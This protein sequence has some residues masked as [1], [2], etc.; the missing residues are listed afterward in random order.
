M[1]VLL[2][3][4]VFPPIC[5]GSGWSTY[6]LARGLRARGHEITI[7]RPRIGRPPDE[8]GDFDGFRPLEFRA[9]APDVP[10]AR[11]Y[12]KTD[13]LCRRLAG[14]LRPLI[15]ERSID[16]VHAQHRLTGPPSVAAARAEGVPVVCTIRDYWP[17]C[18]WSDLIHDPASEELCP[19]CTPGM[20]TRCIRPRAGRLWPLAA[21]LIPYMRASLRRMQ[22]ALA[23]AGAVVAVGSAIARDLVARAPGLDAGRVNIIPNAVDAPGIQEE[24][25]KRARPL[26]QPYALYVGKLETNK[27]VSKLLPAVAAADLDLPLVVVGDGS[28][29]P[30]L[31]TAA[32]E[33]HRD[34]RVV[35]WQAHTDTLAWIRHATLLVFPSHWREPLSRVLLEASALGRPIAAMNSGGT[36][37]IVIHEQTGLLS[38]SVGE[39]GW[40]IAVLR[41]DTEL[42]ARLGAAARRRVEQTFDTPVV[43]D[44]VEALYERLHGAV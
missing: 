26:D 6:E 23:G 10:F 16:L 43:V 24:A 44:Q 18:Y 9:W 32:R 30:A 25:E 39:L 15:R 20:M 31:E 36:C 4:D 37:D 40:H 34:V 7:V 29:R 35:G 1:H 28:G 22:R 11:N 19:A 41:H 14:Y 21:P 17:I 27:G 33:L 12:F 5:G 2:T 3:T 38:R 13:R 42:R 8:A